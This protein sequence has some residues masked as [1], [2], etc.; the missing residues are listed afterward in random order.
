[1]SSART[2]LVM[3]ALAFAGTHPGVGTGAEPSISPHKPV[4][5]IFPGAGTG[6]AIGNWNQFRFNSGHTGFNPVERTLNVDNVSFLSLDFEAELGDPVFSS[7]PAVVGNVVY[8][9]SRDGTLWAFPANGCR[10]SICSKPLWKSTSLGQ[11]VDSPTVANG[12]VYIGSQTSPDNNDGKVSAFAA[13]GCGR[14]VCAPLWQGDAGKEAILESSPTVAD[15][16]VYIG[17]FD[18]RLYAFHA[19]GC[20]ATEC[21]PAWI[22]ATGGTVESTPTVAN[23]IV[24]IG[25][26]D[27]FLYAFDARGCGRQNCPPRWRG[28]LAGPKLVSSV[29]DSTPAVANGVVYIGSAHSLAAF[30]AAGC[31]AGANCKPIWQA[32]DQLQFFGGSPAVADGHVYIGLESS[33]AVYSA[34]GCGKDLCDALW[35]LT[36]PGSQASVAS[37]PTVANGVVYAGRNSGDVF[38]WSAD[39]CG[40]FTCDPL[41]SGHIN[42]VIVN[43]SPT[44]VRGKLYIGSGDNTFPSDRQG[45]LYVFGLVE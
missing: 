1:M 25:S 37:S 21:Q 42:D 5:G 17:A 15:G 44:V 29:F 19:N 16:L 10:D 7:S 35:L 36:G 38:A 28:E 41:W 40:S 43:S 31:G 32:V 2:L 4:S 14:E 11:I 3:L 6:T 13:A 22:G 8:I 18:G 24:Y 34:D 20:G 27:G 45:S 26:D 12:T 33:V 30:D 23:G 9:A 39:A